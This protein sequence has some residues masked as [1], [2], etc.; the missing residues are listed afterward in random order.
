MG[1][2][3]EASENPLLKDLLFEEDEASKKKAFL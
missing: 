3:I 1:E 2:K